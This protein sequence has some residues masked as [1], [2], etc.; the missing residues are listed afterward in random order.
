[1]ALRQL[2]ELESASAAKTL[3][4]DLTCEIMR[5]ALPKLR[6][7][8]PERVNILG[9]MRGARYKNYYGGAL[10]PGWRP[11]ITAE[12]GAAAQIHRSTC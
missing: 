2:G 11:N 9:M 6:S 7:R 10:L 5:E 12:E 4:L 8:H 1:M 3:R